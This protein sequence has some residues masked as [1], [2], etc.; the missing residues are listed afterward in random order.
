MER[1]VALPEPDDSVAASYNLVSRL[2]HRRH[3]YLFPNP[4][5]PLNWGVMG[6]NPHD[7]ATVEWIVVDRYA[8]GQED[9][10][11]VAHIMRQDDWSILIDQDGI[12]VAQRSPEP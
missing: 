4:W 6:E 8:I 5:Q 10:A 7:P 2:T 9:W 1:A 3:V 12:L 11:L